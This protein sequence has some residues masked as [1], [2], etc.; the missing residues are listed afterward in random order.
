MNSLTILKHP[1]SPISKGFAF[2]SMDATTHLTKAGEFILLF[3][4]FDSCGESSLLEQIFI[5]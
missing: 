1:V 5:S 2:Y 4:G 3:H